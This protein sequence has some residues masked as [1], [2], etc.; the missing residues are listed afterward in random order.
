MIRIKRRES[1]VGVC[2]GSEGKGREWKKHD[3]KGKK[4]N[5]KISVNRK[6]V[7]MAGKI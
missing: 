6:S 2:D 7:S 1:K 5:E 4:D 3:R